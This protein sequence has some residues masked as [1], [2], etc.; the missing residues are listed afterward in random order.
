MFIGHLGA[1]LL[2]KQ[3][4]R[5][6]NLGVLFLASL[7]LDFLL[8]VFVLLDVEQII[9]PEDYASRHYLLLSSP[10]SHGLLASILWALLFS[11]VVWFAFGKKMAFS[12][13]MMTILSA[14]VLVHY[15]LDV[16]VH[17]PDLPVL[18]RESWHLGLG[19]WNHLPI[20]LTLEVGI[21]VLGMWFYFHSYRISWTKAIVFVV[22]MLFF[23]LMMVGGMTMTSEPP[24]IVVSA[25]FWVITPLILFFLG[26]WLDSKSK[27]TQPS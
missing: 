21:L 5:R 7:L 27:A 24:D 12:M 23:T 9:V 17:V 22:V 8:G 2:L 20:A 18:G 10:Y 6:I 14:A 3:T 13:R 1:G 19:L 11:A 16:I 25:V 15:W 4:E 26:Y